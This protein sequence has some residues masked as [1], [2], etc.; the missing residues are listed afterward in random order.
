MDGFE[1]VVEATRS[2]RKPGLAK[3]QMTILL[4]PNDDHISQNAGPRRRLVKLT[5]SIASTIDKGQLPSY[6][7]PPAASQENCNPPLTTYG[8]L[9][10]YTV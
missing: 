5:K 8:N 10:S 9:F 2:A 7:T 1:P 4:G 3:D 6:I